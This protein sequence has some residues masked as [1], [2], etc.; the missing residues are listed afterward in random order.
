M[1]L[2][3][4]AFLNLEQKVQTPQAWQQYLQNRRMLWLLVHNCKENVSILVH[5]EKK[6]LNCNACDA[7][8]AE[9]GNLNTNVT[10][11]HEEIKHFEC[12]ICEVSF[13]VKQH[14]KSHTDLVHEGKSKYLLRIN[15]AHHPAAARWEGFVQVVVQGSWTGGFHT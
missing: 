7:S 11:V 5:E 2:I 10:Y 14:I 15:S 9:K 12:N 8:F 6:P 3:F 1:Q 13:I 4:E